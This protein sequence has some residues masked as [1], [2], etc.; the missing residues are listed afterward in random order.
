[1]FLVHSTVTPCSGATLDDDL[2]QG[3]AIT[4]GDVEAL[5]AGE[6][7]LHEVTRRAW[8]RC[9]LHTLNPAPAVLSAA[10]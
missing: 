2:G 6:I 10:T 9:G 5:L 1:M 4:F 3:S 8:V 7:D